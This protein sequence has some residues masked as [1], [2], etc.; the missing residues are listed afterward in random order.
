MRPI[1]TIRST[2]TRFPTFAPR[3]KWLVISYWAVIIFRVSTIF[4][5]IRLE[6]KRSAEKIFVGWLTNVSWR[7]RN[8]TFYK[9]PMD[10]IECVELMIL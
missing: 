3:L 10:Y 6:F 9:N 5:N 4:K 2:N 7:V 8:E 1:T